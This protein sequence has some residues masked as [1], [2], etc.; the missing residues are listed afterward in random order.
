VTPVV[1]YLV[2]K[3]PG[4]SSVADS[5]GTAAHEGSVS[6]VTFIAAQ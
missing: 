4:R 5:A 1:S 2:L 6:A 3:C